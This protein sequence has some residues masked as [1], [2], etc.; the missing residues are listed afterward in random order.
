MSPN[1]KRKNILM[2]LLDGCEFSVFERMEEARALAP[3]ITS[4]IDD[5][6]L[7][8]ITSN[9][10]ITQVSLP[11]ILTQTYPLDFGGYNFGIRY[12]PKSMIESLKDH[13]YKTYFIAAHDITGPRR[14]YERGADVVRT[15]YDNDDTVE[16]Y[17]RLVLNYEI[18]LWKKGIISRENL[19]DIL[20]TEFLD[21]LNYAER[22]GD[23][24]YR[25]LTP[26]RLCQ[27][28]RR[29]AC[30]LRQERELLSRDVDAILFKLETVPSLHYKSFLGLDIRRLD[31]KK[32][33]RRLKSYECL[34]SFKQKANDIFKRYSGLGI[35]LFPTYLSPTA[36]EVLDEVLDVIEPNLTPWFLFAQLMDHHDGAKTSR[37]FS[38]LKKRNLFFKSYL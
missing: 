36:R 34:N 12:R 33:Y 24:F 32:L 16:D 4:L 25:L 22:G 30:K 29:M 18:D 26:G 11:A 23:R 27:P 6:C 7:Q 10:M 14:M 3:T 9:G 20:K 38:F 13:G 31:Q 19:E 37:Y 5:G 1:K 35:S 17:I 21:I 2:L 8:K 15:I 28:S